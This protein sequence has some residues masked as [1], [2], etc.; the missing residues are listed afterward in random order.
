MAASFRRIAKRA[1]GILLSGALLR[2]I[3]WRLAGE[4]TVTVD[5]ASVVFPIETI[6]DAL[7]L[8]YSIRTEQF[9]I[10]DLLTELDTDDVI[11]DVG[12][13][14][15]LYAAF[16]G[17]VLD[18]DN[19]VAFEPYDPNLHRLGATA[20]VNDLDPE[21]ASVAL[22]DHDGEVL[23]DAP[24]RFKAIAGTSTI[25]SGTA[26]GEV[27]VPARTGDSLVE[28]GELPHPTVI[29]IDVEGSEPLVLGGLNQTLSDPRVRLVYC[30]IHTDSLERFNSSPSAVCESFRDHGFALN[31]LQER[32]NELHVKAVR[33]EDR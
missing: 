32:E 22:S 2:A 21:V 15:G 33:R 26:S 10:S 14:Y 3:K 19:V 30:E 8:D 11:F 24:S 9:V 18:D 16:A 13:N 5:E 4:K 7:V 12:A 1:V 31:T 25:R 17:A 23:F 6:F 29:K 20:A 28:A 27:A